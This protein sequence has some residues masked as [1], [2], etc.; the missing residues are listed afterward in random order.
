MRHV[1]NVNHPK[2]LY[3]DGEIDGE[4]KTNEAPYCEKF[5][6]GKFKIGR[7]DWGGP[8]SVYHFSGCLR[9][10]RVWK[11]A[12]TR[13]E[14]LESICE[15]LTGQEKGLLY[16]WPMDEEKGEM[17]KDRTSR[18]NHAELVNVCWTVPDF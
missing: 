18:Q 6:T 7:Y 2:S 15:K 12:R 17:V 5:G 10:L 11:V 9:E 3:V 4:I 14:I 8:H 13:S 1:S 16:Y